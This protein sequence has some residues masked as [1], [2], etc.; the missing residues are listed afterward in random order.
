[1]LFLKVCE[2]SR[3]LHHSSHLVIM[4]AV[5]LAAPLAAQVEP[6]S[7]DFGDVAMTP[8]TDLG[9]AGKEIP[10][11]LRVALDDPY[12]NTGLHT[13]NSLIGAIVRLDSVLGK[14]YDAYV[15][16]KGWLDV[17]RAAQSLIGSLLIPFRGVVREVSGAAGRE[18]AMQAAVTA[19]LVRR[20]YLK[21]L[22]AARGC[23]EPARPRER[24]PEPTPDEM[25]PTEE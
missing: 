17:G 25:T 1:M 3:H 16:G 4:C 6:E 21:G 19:G 7:P 14:D 24:P 5:C 12:A 23:D 20:G 8:L 22:G 11:A 9:L 13:C 2:T 18:R 10:E 15:P